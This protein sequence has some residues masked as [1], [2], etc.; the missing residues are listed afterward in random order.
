MA[1]MGLWREN[2]D[3]VGLIMDT[4]LM[5]QQAECRY[6]SKKEKSMKLFLIHFPK[7][8]F[9]LLLRQLNIQEKR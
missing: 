5:Q 3:E 7:G 9:D 2:F 6:Q 4:W 1:C 8:S